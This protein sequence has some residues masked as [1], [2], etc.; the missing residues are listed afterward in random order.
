MRDP[1]TALD[2]NEDHGDMTIEQKNRRPP[3]GSE[4]RPYGRR[5]MIGSWGQ[6]PY[7]IYARDT[8][9]P[10]FRRTNATAIKIEQNN[11]KEPR[12]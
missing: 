5:I 3:D 12:R 11:A 7:R 10:P 9:L 2:D 1:S 8:S 4:S 6:P